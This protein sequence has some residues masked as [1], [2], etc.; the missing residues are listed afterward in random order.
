MEELMGPPGHAQGDR[1]AGGEEDRACGPLL[2][3]EGLATLQLPS[4]EPVV[5]LGLGHQFSL[6]FTTLKISGKPG[7]CPLCRF[8]LLRNL[9]L[10]QVSHVLRLQKQL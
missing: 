1:S 3:G 6:Q 8:L 4:S 5:Q 10:T 9:T 7:R 2:A